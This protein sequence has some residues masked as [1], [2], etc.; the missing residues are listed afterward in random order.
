MDNL[1]EKIEQAEESALALL[2]GYKISIT[3]KQGRYIVDMRTRLLI[4]RAITAALRHEYIPEDRFAPEVSVML[5]S[6]VLSFPL[7]QDGIPTADD[8]DPETGRIPLGDIV[9]SLDRAHAQAIEY[10]HSFE[11]ELAFLCVHS[12][13]HLLGYDHE[14]GGEDER[15]MFDCQREILDG[16]GL[17]R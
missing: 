6:D 12:V 1:L 16:M 5:V 9:I 7:L 14:G 4:R 17:T 8:I 15:I 3:N 13:L 11:R 2:P 10:G